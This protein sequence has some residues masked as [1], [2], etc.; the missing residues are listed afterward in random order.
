[1]KKLLFLLSVGILFAGSLAHAYSFN[2]WPGECPTAGEGRY[3]EPVGS[4]ATYSS[5]RDPQAWVPVDSWDIFTN[6]CNSTKVGCGDAFCGTAAGNPRATQPP[7]NMC[8]TARIDGPGPSL[9]DD[10]WKWQCR[11][12]FHPEVCSNRRSYS[13]LTKCNN[14]RSSNER[15]YDVGTEYKKYYP[16]HASCLD[17]RNGNPNGS[18][19]AVSLNGNQRYKLCYTAHSISCGAE[20][21]S[22][23]ALITPAETLN[24]DGSKDVYFTITYSGVKN[25]KF[26]PA[27]GDPEKDITYNGQ[28]VGPYH[29]D[30]VAQPGGALLVYTVKLTYETIRGDNGEYYKADCG[31]SRVVPVSVGPPLCSI[32]GLTASP[33]SFSAVAEGLV[34]FF[35]AGAN[36]YWTGITFGDGQSSGGSDDK[37]STEAEYS[38]NYRI[39]ENIS[40]KTFTATV[41]G[42]HNVDGT[43]CGTATANVSFTGVPKSVQCSVYPTTPGESPFNVKAIINNPTGGA[44]GPCTIS[45][46]GQPSK[47]VNLNQY[48]FGTITTKINRTFNVNVDCNGVTATCSNTVQAP[49]SSTGGEVAP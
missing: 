23:S 41:T 20:F 17:D 13:T 2:P 8:I 5:C 9:T 38:H 22:C 3:S 21:P 39:T 11:G 18:C 27:N 31:D 4:D 36:V 49:K 16:D 7:S 42:R 12:P 44:A 25:L 29:Y 6:N 14:A 15:C 46:D 43:A 10:K 28:K 24:S 37:G 30:Y 34:N 19:Q 33:S 26:N 47:S 1:M 40:S 35:A 45:F 48:I 32:T